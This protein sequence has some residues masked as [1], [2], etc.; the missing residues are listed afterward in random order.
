MT[1]T[2]DEH[3]CLC[4][5]SCLHAIALMSVTNEWRIAKYSEIGFFRYDGLKK[6]WVATLSDGSKLCLHKGTKASDVVSLSPLFQQ[7]HQSFIVNFYHVKFVGK[8]KIRLHNP[9]ER[10]ILPIGRSFLPALSDRLKKT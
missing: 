2:H 7:I 4:W 8:T 9:F 5:E 3:D 1:R 6:L 10:Y